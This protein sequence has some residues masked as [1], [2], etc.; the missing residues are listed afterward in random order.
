[1]VA[2]TAAPG[3]RGCGRSRPGD[4]RARRR[5]RRRRR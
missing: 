1:V 3:W 5:C 4:G 2:L